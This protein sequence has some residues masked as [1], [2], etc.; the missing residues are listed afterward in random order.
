VHAI[1][2][3]IASETGLLLNNEIGSIIRNHYSITL[4]LIQSWENKKLQSRQLVIQPKFEL[5]HNLNTSLESFECSQH[6][7]SKSAKYNVRDKLPSMLFRLY[8]CIRY[9]F[10]NLICF[11]VQEWSNVMVCNEHKLLLCLRLP[12][13]QRWQ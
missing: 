5:W 11:M 6:A 8:I 10:S 12:R 1:S 3:I 9:H 2:L 4:G 13:W 7:Q